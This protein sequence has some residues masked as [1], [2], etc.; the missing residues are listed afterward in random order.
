MA[1]AAAAPLRAQGRGAAQAPAPAPASAASQ[2][3]PPG[4]IR[5][6]PKTAS[7]YNDP[8]HAQ[9][10]RYQRFL[11]DRRLSGETEAGW[12]ALTEEQR[13]AKLAQG[14]A[15]LSSF[16][17]SA[18]AGAAQLSAVQTDMIRAVWGDE[19]LRQMRGLLTARQLGDASQV[20]SSLSRVKALAA[21]VGDVDVDWEGVF[22]G[23]LGRVELGAQPPQ[24]YTNAAPA[25]PGSFLDLIESPEVKKIVSRREY[26]AAFLQQRSVPPPAH[27]G[28]LALYDTLEAAKD[29]DE[30]KQLSH[31]VPTVV[32]L[33]RDG[34]SVELMPMEGALGLAFPGEYD[35][36][37]KIGVAV[38]IEKADPLYAADVLAHEI[39][40]IY[41]MYTGRYYTLDSEIRGFKTGA[42][43]MTAG[44]RA[45][46]QKWEQLRK[47]DDEQ[48]RSWADNAVEIRRYY[49]KGPAEFGEYIA[50]GYRYN[51][52]NEGVFE[53]RLPLR[54][55]VDPNFGPAR[56]ISAVVRMQEDA[57]V[58]LVAAERELNEARAAQA[59]APSREA[60]RRLEKATRD[61]Y[62]ARVAVSGF[63]HRHTIQ[64]L[65]L[66]RMKQEADWAFG[67]DPNAPYDLNLQVDR[68]YVTP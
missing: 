24:N 18:S 52:Y 6:G 61:A 4:A 16:L 19:M 39:Q 8:A 38:G 68:R 35:R 5:L 22:D 67:K 50:F 57:R 62:G 10:F 23:A 58:Q 63:E 34:K 47:S 11:L 9:F 37:E 7:G 1:L 49:G 12:T 48:T 29:T 56:E 36:P 17:E 46:P 43:F 15:H 33:L 31:L 66:S 21:K 40:H 45:A 60:D 14:E 26:F 25:R 30:G 59:R 27:P 51:Q 20:A 55:A 53:G 64:S 28:L 44:E 2:T 41:D 42:L 65:R 3:T 54:Q 13:A 32:Q